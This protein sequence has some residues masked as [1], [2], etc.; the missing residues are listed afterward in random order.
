MSEIT[1]SLYLGSCHD[2]TQATVSSCSI[3][4]IVNMTVELDDVV[5]PGVENAR[6]PLHDLP[7]GNI[8]P[9]LNGA[10]DKIHQIISDGGKVLVHCVRGN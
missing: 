9:V 3:T 1:A 2:V 4:C 10:A 6:F 8:P 7:E 5:L